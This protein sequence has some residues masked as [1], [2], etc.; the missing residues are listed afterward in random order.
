MENVF[1]MEQEQGQEWPIW[2]DTSKVS[3]WLTCVWIVSEHSE[4]T[5]LFVSIVTVIWSENLHLLEGKLSDVIESSV[6][7][8]FK[9]DQ[10]SIYRMI[11]FFQILGAMSSKYITKVKQSERRSQQGSHQD[12]QREKIR[13]G[14][15]VVPMKIVNFI[16]LGRWRKK[17]SIIDRCDIL[18]AHFWLSYA[19][20]VSGHLLLI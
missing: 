5:N 13:G 16:S 19:D 14:S 12:L 18:R 7:L 15:S 11:M 9:T 1:I 3:S 8:T 20:I 4:D 2:S 17:Y 10:I 6:C